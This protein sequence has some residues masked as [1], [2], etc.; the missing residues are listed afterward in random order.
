MKELSDDIVTCADMAID[1]RGRDGTGDWHGQDL[2]AL[3]RPDMVV[4]DANAIMG[5]PPGGGQG[6]AETGGPD[7]KGTKT[8]IELSVSEFMGLT[9]AVGGGVGVQVAGEL[10]GLEAIGAAGPPAVTALMTA[11]ITAVVAAGVL[12]YAGGTLLNKT[13]TVQS[14][15]SAATDYLVYGNT[16]LKIYDQIKTPNVTP[17]G[18]WPAPQPPAEPIQIE[19]D[20]SINSDNMYWFTANPGDTSL[21]M[22][23]T[24]VEA[25]AASVDLVGTMMGNN[26]F[27]LFWVP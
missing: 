26:L 27:A 15:V 6:W 16:D 14:W 21:V 3:H 13:E 9:A 20:A 17:V 22:W 18:P 8:G 11:G 10:I 12:G 7:G 24:P 25:L 2:P 4:L 1:E 5:R 23:D 19:Y